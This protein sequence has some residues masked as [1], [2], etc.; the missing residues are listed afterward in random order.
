MHAVLLL[1]IYII[2]C[3]Q[4]AYCVILGT[5]ESRIRPET[6]KGIQ[7][8]TIKHTIMHF[9]FIHI[10]CMRRCQLNSA[11]DWFQARWRRQKVIRTNWNVLRTQ[12]YELETSGSRRSRWNETY[13]TA[14]MGISIYYIF[15]YIILKV[16]SSV[17]WFFVNESKKRRRTIE[18]QAI[19]SCRDAICKDLSARKTDHKSQ[20]ECCSR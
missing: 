8:T 2:L 15:I 16:F 12:S 14:S 9:T 4:C 10:P 3:I 13:F 7:L 6:S 20:R 19:T 18:K 1:F 5:V 17:Q 11:R